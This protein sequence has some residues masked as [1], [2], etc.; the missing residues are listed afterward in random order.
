MYGDLH[1]EFLYLKVLAGIELTG[2]DLLFFRP[3]SAID[4]FL[5][6]RIP[7]YVKC[8]DQEIA[9]RKKQGRPGPIE[10]LLSDMPTIP[11]LEKWLRKSVDGEVMVDENGEVHPYSFRPSSV[12]G[13]CRE[14]EIKAGRIFDLFPNPV[15]CSRKYIFRAERHEKPWVTY[16]PKLFQSKIKAKGLVVV[17]F[18]DCY[19]WKRDLKPLETVKSLHDFRKQSHL[20][21][22]GAKYTGRHLD[23]GKLRLFEI[24]CGRHPYSVNTDYLMFDQNPFLDTCVEILRSGENRLRVKH[25]L[26]KIGEGWVSETKLF[27]LVKALFP[28]AIQ[29]A[30]PKWLGRQ[31]L[32][33]FVPSGSFAIEYHGR[34][35]YEPV[36]FFGGT[37][38]FESTRTR[39][40]LKRERCKKNGIILLEWHYDV[41]ID[42]KALREILSAHRIKF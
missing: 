42:G 28:D 12:S 29:H 6:E 2:R 10:I 27:S 23:F 20:W 21:M 4:A 15:L 3:K 17:Q 26:P 30:R 9:S 18:R 1:L 24:V 39:D 36:E 41:Q 25:G 11:E 38:Q 35:H 5:G 22:Y 37:S 40:A 13:L 34:Q 8:L 32:D 16:N 7:E 33:V 19:Q 14:G 31:H